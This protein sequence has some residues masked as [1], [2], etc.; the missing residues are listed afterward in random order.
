MKLPISILLSTLLATL[1]ACA[2]PPKPQ[3]KGGTVKLIC[4]PSI[5]TEAVTVTFY[6]A[7]PSDL[8]WTVAGTTSATAQPPTI[9]VSNS[10]YGEVFYCVFTDAAGN[11][12]DPSNTATNTVTLSAPG[13]IKIKR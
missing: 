7:L 4:D 3:A 10:V 12:T 11:D 1:P 8:V 2:T 5:Q 9:T 6:R 13:T